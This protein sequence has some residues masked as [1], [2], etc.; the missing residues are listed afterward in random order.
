MDKN[1]VLTLEKLDVI[2]NYLAALVEK[3]EEIK[4]QEMEPTFFDLPVIKETLFQ[5]ELIQKQLVYGENE[6]IQR[7]KHE[8]Q[9]L[10]SKLE[11]YT[12]AL[13]SINKEVVGLIEVLKSI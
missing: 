3:Y 8:N 13:V 5:K 9:I 12:Q 1:I 4:R 7:L 2:N 6:E 11:D 10:Q